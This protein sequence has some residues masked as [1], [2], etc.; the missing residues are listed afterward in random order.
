MNDIIA[1][2]R[3]DYN[4]IAEHFSDTRYDKKTTVLEQFKEYLENGQSILDW[5]C[6]NG[7]LLFLL[8]D[9]DVTYVGTDQSIELIKIAQDLWKEAI[10]KGKAQFFCTEE[11][12]KEFSAEYF[13]LVFLIAS[14]HHLPD[15]ES[16]KNLLDKI[17]VEMKS[18]GKLIMTNW[19][20]ESDWA[21]GKL[22]KDWEKLSNNDFL[23]PW[24]NRQGE[25]IVKRYY[26]HFT[27][28]ELRMLL[29]KSGF[30]I[31]KLFYYAITSWSD[32]KG[33]QN[34][35]AVVSKP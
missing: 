3:E 2:T 34:L 10:E 22:E 11:Q 1:K 5:G 14:F 29:E 31:E 9:F 19:N 21:Q 24:K 33:G 20:L 8:K 6:G 13:D 30:K 17:F 12:E 4:R 15:E 25:I 18:G 32:K 26:H 16:R 35:V 7:R 28:Q 23:I 27:E